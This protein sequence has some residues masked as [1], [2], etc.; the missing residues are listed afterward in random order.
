MKIRSVCILGGSG[1]V[2]RA[3]ASQLS[4]RG[5]RMRV[6][7][8][9][10]QS[11]MPLTVF[12]TAEIAV[13]DIHD[14]QALRRA[15]EDMDAVVNLVGILH[16]GGNASFS[17]CHA[18]L[19]R[20]VAEACKASGVRHLLHMSALGVSESAPSAYLRSKAAGEA[21][22][23]EAA[24][25]LPWTVFRP[26]VIF[27]E[28]D[29]SINT[30]AAWLRLLPFFPLARAGARVQPVWVEDVAR[31]F[32]AALGDPRTFGQVYELG[33]PRAYTWRELVQCAGEMSGNPRAVIG[34]PD[35]VGALQAT[36]L[37]WAPRPWRLMSRD[38]F[39]S[40]GVD[41]VTKARFPEV[42]GIVPSALETVAP[43]Y[44]AAS[45]ARAR[46]PRYRHYAGR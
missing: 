7:T 15:F 30:F 2:G 18:E 39:D 35:A 33:G 17:R 41:N 5:L 12:P 8:R 24:G 20:K 22:L 19:P 4:S 29:R 36:V 42:F 32:A 31:C 40:M 14:P 23:R 1:F 37:G 21:A 44:L 16:E 38:N 25:I 11:A 13:A 9:Q 6:V 10:R 43:E 3:L 28:G 34:L 46:Y 27:G 45:A 26:S